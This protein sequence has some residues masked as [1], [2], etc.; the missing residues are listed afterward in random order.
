MESL[1]KPYEHQIKIANEAYKVLKENLLVYLSMQERTGK[2]LTSILISEMSKSK[3]ILV[4]TKKKAIEGWEDTLKRFEH[5]KIYTIINY[6]SLHK[7][8]GVFDLIIVDEAHSKIA[9]FPKTSKTWKELYKFTKNKPIIYLSATPSAQTRAQLYHQF[10]LS[11]WSPWSKFRDFYSWFRHYG[12]PETKYIGS[13]PI[14][15]YDK[16]FDD[17]IK[18]ET[19]H[20]FISYT[21]KELGFEHEPN[22]IL[23]YVDLCDKA[24]QQYNTFMKHKVLELED[25]TLV[26]GDT[27]MSLRTRSHQIE[28]GTLVIDDEFYFLGHTDR[29]DYIKNEWGDTNQLVIFYQYRAEK[30]LLEKHFKKATILQGTSFAEGVD[31]SMYKTCVVY[32]MDFSTAKYTQRRARQ[33]N[34]KREEPIDFHFLL[35]KK[36]RSEKVYNTVAVNRMNYVESYFEDEESL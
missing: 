22:D 10:K 33:C 13:R 2:T 19:K 6:E 36:A 20:L 25:G 30:V 12:I 28:G 3:R 7:I 11:S 32:S 4:V 21:R 26:L 15:I 35:T 34:M 17:D 18:E 14:K 31:L 1:V 5:S 23:H 16:V 8:S 24:K 27:P 9:S 29:I